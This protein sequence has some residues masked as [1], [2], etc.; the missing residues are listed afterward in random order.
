M[1][2]LPAIE[3][4]ET[5]MDMLTVLYKHF[6][7]D[8]VGGLGTRRKEWAG[9]E[10]YKFLDCCMALK[11]DP[12]AVTAKGLVPRSEEEARMWETLKAEHDQR[13]V[14]HQM[15]REL[16]EEEDRERKREKEGGGKKPKKA[17][18]GKKK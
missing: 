12:L 6:L 14:S 7:P 18:S 8:K 15:G 10:Q 13:R 5:Y 3:E 4:G 16:L 1:E 2:F 11:I 17:A 9:K